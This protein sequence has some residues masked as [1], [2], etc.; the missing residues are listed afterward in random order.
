ML[1]ERDDDQLL[2]DARR[3]PAAFEELYRR[4]VPAVVKFAARRSSSPEQVVDLVAAIWLEVVASIEHFDP[5][6]GRALSWILG[7]GANL[8]ASDA[9]RRQ[10]E[11]E[12]VTRLA[13][14]RILLEDEYVRLE[15]ELDAVAVVP[16]LLEAIERLPARERVIAELTL[17]DGL[18]PTEAGNALGIR[19][20]TARMRLTRAKRKLR[21]AIEEPEA[22]QEVS[23]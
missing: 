8:C 12:A 23:L 1:T 13:G 17:I 5:K 15:H 18:T 10:R 7:I 21:L 11:R 6:R 4:N 20:P 16:K 14:Q 22:I 19:P 2:M 9:R 3:D